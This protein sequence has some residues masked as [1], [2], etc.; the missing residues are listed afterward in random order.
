MA[1]IRYHGKKW[2][3]QVRRQGHKLNRSFASRAD[4]EAWARM[5]ESRIDRAELPPDR[6][7]LRSL[8]LR[9]LLTRYEACVTPQ[10]RSARHERNRIARLLRHPIAAR[11][12]DTLTASHIAA[13][14][15]E[16]LTTI[17]NQAVLHDL[18]LL[19]HVLQTA[20]LEW[21][22]PLPVNP[23]ARVAKPRMPQARQRRLRQGEFEALHGLASE[24]DQP[25]Y[26]PNLIR[27]AVE[28]GMR[29]GEL[30]SLGWENIHYEE[31]LAHIG[32]TKNGLPR[33]VPLSTTALDAIH[34]QS[35]V[36]PERVFPVSVAALRFHWD[37]LLAVAGITDLHFHDLRH[38]AISRL[39]EMGLSVPEVALVS[40]HLD[41]RQLFRY[42]H[43]RATD[44][45]LKLVNR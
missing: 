30:L 3:V 36:H 9:D 33:S 27:V 2:Q 15:D 41:P 34:A 28:T 39:F 38:E 32:R 8:S 21:S 29:K 6:R 19:N 43:P 24:P 18:H 22:I 17:G 40:G 5:Q 20:I 26:L 37:R 14:R 11:T 7:A 35:G 12:L 13:F 1:T 16:R 25:A 42:T 31:R 44:I 10:K 23:V 45:A 4:A